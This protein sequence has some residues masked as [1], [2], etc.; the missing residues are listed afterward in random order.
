MNDLGFKLQIDCE[1]DAFN[2][3]AA[4]EV[5]RILRETADRLEKGEQFDTYRNLID[6]NGNVVGTAKLAS[7]D[8]L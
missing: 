7:R 3:N 2:D 1:N 6:I 5:A 4:V 8:R